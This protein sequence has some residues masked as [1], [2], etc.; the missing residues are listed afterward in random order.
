MIGIFI[1]KANRCLVIAVIFLIL[2]PSSANA[3]EFV[4]N[5]TIL[6]PNSPPLPVNQSLNLAFGKAPAGN[7]SITDGNLSSY[8]TMRSGSE[9]YID[10]GSGYIIN[11]VII[12]DN[13]GGTGV[14]SLVFQTSNDASSWTT[15]VANS[16][17]GTHNFYP[18]LARFV[19]VLSSPA[20]NFYKLY[21]IEI[22]QFPETCTVYKP[23]FIDDGTF[24]RKAFWVIS[25]NTTDN[26]GLWFDDNGLYKDISYTGVFPNPVRATFSQDSPTDF[27]YDVY[28]KDLN[29]KVYFLY[30]KRRNNA[31]SQGVSH[32]LRSYSTASQIV[33]DVTLFDCISTNT[34]YVYYSRGH[35][36]LSNENLTSAG[37]AADTLKFYFAAECRGLTYLTAGISWSNGTPSYRV[38]TS[39]EPGR[40][41]IFSGDI[42]YH[43]DSFSGNEDNFTI[44]SGQGT[45]SYSYV[46]TNTGITLSKFGTSIGE[47]TTNY[48]NIYANATTLAYS[49]NATG[50]IDIYKKHVNGS[51][52]IRLSSSQAIEYPVSVL[53]EPSNDVWVT[54]LND[55]KQYVREVFCDTDPSPIWGQRCSLKAEMTAAQV[56][57]DV[58]FVK[59]KTAVAMIKTT[60]NAPPTSTTNLTIYFHFDGQFVG[61]AFYGAVYGGNV[62][63][64]Y[65][66]FTPP[67]KKDN[68][69]MRATVTHN[70]EGYERTEVLEKFVNVTE[71]Y[72][73]HVDFKIIDG[74]NN[75]NSIIDDQFDFIRRIYPVKDSD[76]SKS[77]YS[78]SPEH[79]NLCKDLSDRFGQGT[80]EDV[81]L[82]CVEAL[83]SLNNVFNFQRNLKTIGIVKQGWFSDLGGRY[84]NNIYSNVVGT[85]LEGNVVSIEE[86]YLR[87][88]AAHEMA[89]QLDFLLCDENIGD[90]TLENSSS[91]R[92]G[93]PGCPNANLNNTKT[94]DAQCDLND[95]CPATTLPPLFVYNTSIYENTVL[96]NLMGSMDNQ[97]SRWISKDSY[98]RLLEVQKRVLSTTEDANLFIMSGIILRNPSR[99]ISFP[100]YTTR[101]NPYFTSNPTGNYSI[102]TYNSSGYLLSNLTFQP[103]FLQVGDNQTV[104]TN[105]SFFVFF[106]NYSSNLSTIKMKENTTIIMQVNRTANS[107]DVSFEFPLNGSSY[108][109]SMINVTWNA[110]DVDGDFLSYELYFSPDNKTLIGLA[111]NFTNRSILLN[112]TNFPDCS[113]CLFRVFATDGFNTGESYSDFF[114]ID[115]DL[116]IENFSSVYT[117]GSQR[118]FKFD[119][120]NSLNYSVSNLSWNL[121]TG[122][123]T[124][125]SIYNTTLVSSEKLFVYVYHNYSTSGL[126]NVTSTARSGDLID[127][128]TIQINV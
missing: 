81:F 37:G 95:G 15:Y 68:V 113:Q 103:S 101:G 14:T 22:Y 79:A 34:E 48:G 97:S 62:T 105:V 90:W 77:I 89:H 119:I 10:L 18:H 47:D 73:L 109:N 24:A 125:N 27:I 43:P 84:P 31:A 3:A 120:L 110:S 57:P 54:Y 108:S 127:S 66:T 42:A 117:N 118:I 72:G 64:Q 39:Q 35:V 4:I 65:F 104:E 115:N 122:N 33:S 44:V 49:T 6:C 56:I 82:H 21:E 12:T 38:N 116:R 94:F 93:I 111:T 69:K 1:L 106:I 16:A 75:Y 50:V 86:G 124:I 96:K 70:A 5:K 100:V 83:L 78:F 45:D 26:I 55:S 25:E 29:G 32:V 40:Q 17:S 67:E 121:D 36:L 53:R 9:P 114:T 112:S 107:P 63:R 98:N 102:E 2:L 59:G 71:T 74:L 58:D 92:S 19:R 41:Y 8:V 85:T 76:L 13:R 11:K 61:F 46:L 23:K 52:P 126:F 128:K 51:T 60:F 80:R 28:P 20:G 30:S 123:G 7:E 99:L 91:A 88:N 87:S